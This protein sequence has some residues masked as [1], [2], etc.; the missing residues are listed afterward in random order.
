MSDPKYVVLAIIDDPK[1]IQEENFSITAATVV[2]PL[3][4][5]IILQMIKVIGIPP[6]KND[7][8]KAS[9]NNKLLLKQNANF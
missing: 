5:R 8:L 9:I 2:V 6:P 4:K 7:I 1:K 3:V